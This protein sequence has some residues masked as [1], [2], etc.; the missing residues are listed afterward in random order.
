MAAIDKIYGTRDQYDELYTWLQSTRKKSALKYFYPRPPDDWIADH[1]IIPITNFPCSVD[2]WLR[3][4]CPIRWVLE[5]LDKQ[6][7]M[8]YRIKTY[9]A[10]RSGN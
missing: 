2:Y 8:E 7:N 6:Y 10:E 4:N 9:E 3:L 1:P 5:R